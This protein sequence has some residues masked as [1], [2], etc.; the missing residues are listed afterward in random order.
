MIPRGEAMAVTY[1]PVACA[2]FHR[3]A[4]D[5][6]TPY[7]LAR[8]SR[9]SAVDRLMTVL[10][11]GDDVPGDAEAQL[12]LWLARDDVSWADFVAEGG[13]RGRLVTFGSARSVRSGHAPG[14]ARLLLRAGVDPRP[15]RFFDPTGGEDPAAPAPAQADDGA[16]TTP[17]LPPEE[18]AP[19]A[20]PGSHLS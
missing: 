14:A 8:F 18:P 4:P 11:Q 2:S 17:A 20:Q 12:A 1:V 13:D 16:P 10:C 19:A 15:L 6:G 9:G 5:A 3:G 7:A